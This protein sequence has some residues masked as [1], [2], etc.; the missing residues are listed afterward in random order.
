MA[1]VTERV[2]DTFDDYAASR[3]DARFTGWLRRRAEPDWTAVVEHRFVGELAD[4][5][6]DPVVFR[7]YLVQDFAFVVELVRLVGHAVGQAPSMAAARRLSAFLGVLTDDEND[8]FERAFDAL[9]VP[10]DH[11]SEPPRADVTDAFADL[12]GRAAHE[13]DYEETLA[14]LLAVE[15]IYLAWATSVAEATPGAFY[16]REWIDLHAN[17]EF[18]AF[19]DGLRE[20]LDD[21]GPALN[22][23]RQRR[24]DRGFRRAVSLEVDFF[25]AAYAPG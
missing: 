5:S 4:G 1:G 15:W 25:D 23:R 11:R 13:G 21:R 8:Y 22:A 12:L 6:I 24:L 19:V 3:E 10:R 20:E 14:V 16:L 17:E 9:E 7:R 2:P 18:V